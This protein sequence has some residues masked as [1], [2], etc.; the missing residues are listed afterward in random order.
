[1]FAI[2][3]RA[4]DCPARGFGDRDRDPVEGAHGDGTRAGSVPVTA[5]GA[6]SAQRRSGSRSH[7][8]SGCRSV[9]AQSTTWSIRRSSMIPR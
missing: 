8:T 5:G 9:C 2:F 7:G 3:P 6:R 1:M 4:F